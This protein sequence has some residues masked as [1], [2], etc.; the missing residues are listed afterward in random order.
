MLALAV[1]RMYLVS[2]LEDDTPFRIEQLDRSVRPATGPLRRILERIRGRVPGSVGVKR[3]CAAD[4]VGINDLLGNWDHWRSKRARVQAV[5]R[6]PDEEIFPLFLRPEWCI[7]GEHGY[8]ELQRGL[9]SL[10]GIDELFRGLS[11]PG[12]DPHK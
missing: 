6:R 2:G 12:S 7:E 3:I 9:S 8:Q 11:E 5:R 1:R 4:L 10:L